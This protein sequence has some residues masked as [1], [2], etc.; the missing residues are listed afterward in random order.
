MVDYFEFNFNDKYILSYSVPYG[1]L[2]LFF[3]NY[4][5]AE[6]MNNDIIIHQKNH[7]RSEKER[8]QLLIMCRNIHN[9]FY[10]S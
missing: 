7:L 9:F 3:G 4:L 1:T 5:I 8:R 6:Y 2:L 10:N